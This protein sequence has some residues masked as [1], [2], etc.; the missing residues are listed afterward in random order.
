MLLA[1]ERLQLSCGA[2]VG[3]KPESKEPTAVALAWRKPVL[4]HLKWK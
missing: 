4:V 1:F 3:H 2:R